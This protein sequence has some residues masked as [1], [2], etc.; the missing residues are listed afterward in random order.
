MTQEQD[1]PAWLFPGALKDYLRESRE[2]FSGSTVACSGECAKEYALLEEADQLLSDSIRDLK[3]RGEVIGNLLGVSGYMYWLAAIRNAMSGHAAA[4]FPLLRTALES[5]CYWVKIEGDPKLATIWVE[6]HK[7]EEARKQSR[8]AFAS[9]PRDVA[10]RFGISDPEALGSHLTVLYD[11]L[12]DFG[13][14]PNPR[15]LFDG[16]SLS[17]DEQKAVVSFTA[18]ESLGAFTVRRSMVA[19]VEC[20]AIMAAL[21]R[22]PP[23]AKKEIAECDLSPVEA[24]FV[25]VHAHIEQ[26]VKDGVALTAAPA[27]H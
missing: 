13:A 5:I 19:C 27:R 18:L 21:L 2:L 26:W 15:G 25:R 7:D 16:I 8:D 14:H 3:L 22:C 1:L 17:E 23:I 20:G 4:V 12:I 11:S 6:R 9:A 10:R 24:L